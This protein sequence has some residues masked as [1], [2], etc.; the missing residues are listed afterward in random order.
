MVHETLTR[1]PLLIAAPRKS[2]GVVSNV[3]GKAFAEGKGNG[4]D[5]RQ[6][7]DVNEI[8]RFHPVE[9]I[10]YDLRESMTAMKDMEIIR[11]TN[12]TIRIIDIH[13]QNKRVV[14]CIVGVWG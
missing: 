4:E 14:L 11:N 5:N 12:N 10:G 13:I 3:I 6:L 2:T 8:I 7:I 9:I 1:C